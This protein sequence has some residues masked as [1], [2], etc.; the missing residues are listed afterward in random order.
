M[1]FTLDCGNELAISSSAF[2]Y[3]SHTFV[4]AWVGHPHTPTPKCIIQTQTLQC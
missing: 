3:V 2:L 4:A 1:N